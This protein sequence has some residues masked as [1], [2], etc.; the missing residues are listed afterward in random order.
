MKT[1][2]TL[3]LLA[4]A[5]IA[6]DE[7][8][9]ELR[10]QN[11]TVFK[12]VKV[13]KKDAAELRIMH[14]DGFATVR[15]SDLTPEGLA[16]FGGKIDKLAADRVD[17]E[18]ALQRARSY[19]PPASMSATTVPV[20]AAANQISAEENARRAWEWYQWCEANPN[21]DAQIGPQQRNALMAQAAQILQAWDDVRQQA[22]ANAAAVAARSGSLSNRP[23]VPVGRSYHDPDRVAERVER[24]QRQ[25]AQGVT[26]DQVI[27]QAIEQRRMLL[28]S[29]ADGANGGRLIEPYMLGVTT[30][31][32]P[33][34][35]AWF[36][37]G[38]S[39][40]QQGPGWR[41]YLLAKITGIQM[42]NDTFAPQ[43]S[44]DGTGGGTFQ[45]YI[46][47]VQ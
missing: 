32:N 34:V 10:L 38:A 36:R 13:T 27:A 20:Q 47:R 44:Y 12:Q 29:Y 26:I 35:Q 33:A 19:V 23:A 31:G 24:L 18:R 17:A 21:G 30:D 14:V 7:I 9:P 41:T 43:R 22:Q 5:L 39:A 45:S 16:L 11:G 1:I 42:T 15:L 46:L 4:A 40:S 8:I 25:Q 37:T 3:C 2:L 28:I 6:A